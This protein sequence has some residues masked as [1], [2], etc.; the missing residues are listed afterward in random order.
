MTAP[1]Q[2]E[3]T[4][5]YKQYKD[6]DNDSRQLI[7]PQYKFHEDQTIDVEIYSQ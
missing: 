5:K 3:H 4:L 6:E 7:Q 1:I 2:L